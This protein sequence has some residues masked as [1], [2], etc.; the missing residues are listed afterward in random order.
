MNLDLCFT[1]AIKTDR[2]K[3]KPVFVHDCETC[4]NGEKMKHCGTCNK[5]MIFCKITKYYHDVGIK[6]CM[7][8]KKK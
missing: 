3:E 4:G 1:C 7:W 2:C 6:K 8:W 5:K